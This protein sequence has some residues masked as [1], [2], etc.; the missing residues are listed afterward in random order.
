MFCS[1]CLRRH[2]KQE[3]FAPAVRVV[4]ILLFTDYTPEL[5][6]YNPP[7]MLPFMRRNEIMIA[8]QQK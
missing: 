4:S 3:K 7:W 6:R 2:S 5:A 1:L 8:Y